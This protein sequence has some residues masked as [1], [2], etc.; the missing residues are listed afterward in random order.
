QLTANGGQPVN[1]YASSAGPFNPKGLKCEYGGPPNLPYCL[2][3]NAGISYPVDFFSVNQKLFSI[4]DGPAHQEHNAYLDIPVTLLGV[5]NG[6]NCTTDP[7]KKVCA[8][9]G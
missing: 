9:F 4:Y 1:V 2:S 7:G 8:G 5:A 6:S 3:I